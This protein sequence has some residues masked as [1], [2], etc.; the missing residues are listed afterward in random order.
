MCAEYTLLPHLYSLLQ[1][2]GLSSGNLPKNNSKFPETILVLPRRKLP[3]PGKFFRNYSL[4]HCCKFAES[5]RT[6]SKVINQIQWRTLWRNC[7]LLNPTWKSINQI[8]IITIRMP[9]GSATGVT[10]NFSEN[11]RKNSEMLFFRK[12]YNHS[13]SNVEL[14]IPT[15]MHH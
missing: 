14:I 3:K 13:C 2:R 5:H 6:K 4:I 1:Q 12:N 10:T 8:C 11:F 15:K 9:Y 7:I